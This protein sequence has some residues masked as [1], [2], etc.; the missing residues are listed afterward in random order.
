[1]KAQTNI[2]FIIDVAIFSTV[3]IAVITAIISESPNLYLR[4]LEN[5]KSSKALQISEILLLDPG[6][7]SDWT[8]SN[9][10]RYG[11]S[12]GTKYVIDKDKVK[13]FFDSCQ[14][15]ENY[16]SV[17]D[18]FH[19]RGD[20]FIEMYNSK[21]ELLGRCGILHK[22]SSLSK[23][24]RFGIMFNSTENKYEIVKMVVGVY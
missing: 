23:I 1:M 24:S 10:N 17:R 12:T 20:I 5:E 2:E 21:G 6:D 14:G 9:V 13:N 4:Y 11:L 18:K 7:P 19:V 16:I 8:T 3:I 22:K 15:Y